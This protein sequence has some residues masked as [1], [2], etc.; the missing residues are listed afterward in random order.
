MY[1]DNL[2]RCLVTFFLSCSNKNLL[3]IILLNCIITEWFSIDHRKTKA[4]VIITPIKQLQ[5]LM[6][7]VQQTNQN[8]KQID[9]EK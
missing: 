2:T 3:L 4:K 8:L 5:K 6:L 1:K 7:I 9:R